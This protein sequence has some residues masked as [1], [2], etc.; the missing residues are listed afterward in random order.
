MKIFS[1]FCYIILGIIVI[2]VKWW[3]EWEFVPYALKF[4]TK[5]MTLL[6]QSTDPSF[7]IV[8]PKKT[9]AAS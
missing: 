1:I 7:A 6:M 3:M 9:V 2:H 8:E 5:T 4:V